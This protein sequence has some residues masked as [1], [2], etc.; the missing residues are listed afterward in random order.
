MPIQIH[1]MGEELQ[2]TVYSVLGQRVAVYTDNS[3]VVNLPTGQY[4]LQVLDSTNEPQCQ[5]L[6]VE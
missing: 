1:G 2:I 5:L 6:I 4:I 3:F